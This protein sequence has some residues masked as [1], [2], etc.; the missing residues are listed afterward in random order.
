MPVYGSECNVRVCCDAAETAPFEPQA[1]YWFLSFNRLTRPSA[2]NDEGC[3]QQERWAKIEVSQKSDL[4]RNGHFRCLAGAF[5]AFRPND[6]S[7]SIPF[8]SRVKHTPC[9]V[10]CRLLR[11]FRGIQRQS[12]DRQ[13]HSSTNR[14]TDDD[15]WHR[16]HRGVPTSTPLLKTQ[17]GTIRQSSSNTLGETWKTLPS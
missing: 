12:Q 11:R 15:R 2:E 10:V 7:H 16:E 1:A 14:I 17:Y 8:H 5:I 3:V 9:Q 4:P 13:R 6:S